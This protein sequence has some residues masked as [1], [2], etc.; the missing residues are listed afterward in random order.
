VTTLVLGGWPVTTNDGAG[1]GG[2]NGAGGEEALVDAP[3]W[4]AEDAA[5]AVEL[6]PSL[7]GRARMHTLDLTKFAQ[8]GATA[9]LAVAEWV[10]AELKMVHS[11][12]ANHHVHV[13]LDALIAQMKL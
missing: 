5:S 8:G 9:K 2:L 13:A 7:A 3:P 4:S 1:G 10:V 6:A 12:K 11:G